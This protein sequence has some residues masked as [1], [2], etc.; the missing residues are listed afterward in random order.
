MDNGIDLTHNMTERF[1]ISYYYASPQN[2]ERIKAFLDL[3]GDSEKGLITQFVRGWIGRNRDY[4]LNLARIDSE[5]RGLSFREWGET[6]F[7][8]GV[9]ALP[10]YIREVGSD[11]PLNPLR[12]VALTPDSIRRPVNY[13]TL[14]VQNTCLLRVAI[15]Y[16]RDNTVGYVSRIVKEHLDRNWEKLYASQVEAEDFDNWR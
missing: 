3:S 8:R 6:V 10:N 13:I 5:S 11:I 4:C 7:F 15:L 2:V 12:D 16:D 14:G 9:E 1:Q